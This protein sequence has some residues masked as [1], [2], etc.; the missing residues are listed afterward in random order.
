MS[1][2]DKVVR[3]CPGVVV[4][5]KSASEKTT[6][7][8]RGP[9]WQ[10]EVP[11]ESV[12]ESNLDHDES[13]DDKSQ[14]PCLRQQVVC[15]FG[16]R[17]ETSWPFGLPLEWSNPFNAPS[18]AECERARKLFLNIVSSGK[19]TRL[20]FHDLLFDFAMPSEIRPSWT[21]ITWGLNW[22]QQRRHVNKNVKT[23]QSATSRPPPMQPQKTATSR[24]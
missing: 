16:D 1:L 7:R 17:N 22:L 2:T 8:V 20:R 4:G 6:C 5:R 10:Y 23:W 14:H 19:W 18:S 12:V 15:G 3:P 13:P 9:D 24:E 11:T 21:L